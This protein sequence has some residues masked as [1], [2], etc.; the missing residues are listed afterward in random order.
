MI[1]IIPINDSMKHVEESTCHCFPS[2]LIE[3]G[4]MILV[5]NSFDGRENREFSVGERA[6]RK[7][8]KFPDSPEEWIE[9]TVNETYL[10]LIAQYP[11]DYKKISAIKK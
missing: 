2:L 1:Q 10:G 11:E 6:L 7:N 4:E 9:F 3:D 5:H 8:R